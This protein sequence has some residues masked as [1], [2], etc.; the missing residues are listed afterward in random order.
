MYYIKLFLGP[1]LF[2]LV[3]FI[4][5][6]T[7]K[8]EAD[9]TAG[10]ACW[11]AAWWMVEVV[12]LMVTSFL[13][14]IM[15]PLLGIAD[16]KIIAAQYMDQVIFLFIGGFIMG[17]AIEKTGLH[18]R[19]AFG[20][21]GKIGSNPTGLLAAVMLSA[22]LISN[23]ISNTATTML[24]LSAVT[25]IVSNL[26]LEPGGK[27]SY[28]SALL[29]GLAYSAS[30]GGM[31]TLVGTPPNMVFMGFY[32]EHFP[33][34]MEMDF[35]KWS[36]LGFPISLL[37]LGFTFGVLWLFFIRKEAVKHFKISERKLEPEKWSPEEKVVAMVFFAAAFLWLTRSDIEIASVSWKGWSR[38][39]PKDFVQDST[40]AMLASLVLMALPV[41][42]RGED[43]ETSSR[44]RPILQFSDVKG[45]PFDIILLFGSG[46]ALSKGF[47]ISGL[48]NWLAS[49]LVVFKG[50]SLILLLIGLCLLVTIISEFASNVASI[51]LVL[52]ILLPLASVLGVDPLV[53]M[54]PATLSASLGFM[55]PVATA[56]NTI[57]F[58]TGFIRT[59]EMMK[60][61]WL[62]DLG[63]I[64]I[65][66]L[67]SW[68]TFKG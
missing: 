45:L 49:Q 32:N 62:I 22:Y 21:M 51:Q 9:Y 64:V 18:K 46:F 1:I 5:Q 65:I 37:L 56:P 23:W 47:E 50:T 26:G 42:H 68:L 53:L 13:P 29:I 59:K 3:G 17:F 15:F 31:A 61:G 7:G 33:N 2:V 60:V 40:V 55:L 35:L 25:S 27:S 10:I 20:I 30:I 28:P 54:I 36:S 48:S 34:Q 58:G 44:F 11:M 67:I 43:S 12:H 39:F 19:I 38:L 8:A 24:L 4:I 63:G 66:S 6:P 57:V 41:F 16:S 52:P 14:I